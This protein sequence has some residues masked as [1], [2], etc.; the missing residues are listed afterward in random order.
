MSKIKINYEAKTYTLEYTREV[1]KIM[2]KQGFDM[3][4]IESQP[5]TQITLLFRGAFI[6]NHREIA[7]KT[8]DDILEEIENKEDLLRKLVTMYQ[9][10]VVTLIGESSKKEKNAT[11]EEA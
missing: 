5:L 10:T 11:W 7:I 9:E 6:Q 3:E 8:V 1:V 2:E 4:K